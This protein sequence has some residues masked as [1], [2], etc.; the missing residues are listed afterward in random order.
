MQAIIIGVDLGG[1]NIKAGAIT[2]EGNVL[3]RCHRPTEGEGGPEKVCDNMAEAVRECRQNLP[4]GGQ[5]IGMGVGTPGPLDLAR[6]LVVDAPNLPGWENIPVRQMMEERTGLE[7]ELENDANAAALGEQWVGAGHGGSSLVLLTLGTGI[8]GGIVL[9]G[10]VW[11][12]FGDCAG[13]IGHMSID[14]EGPR[15][16]CGNWGCVEAHASATAMVRRMRETIE[17]GTGSSLADKLDEMTA[18]DIY[19]AAVDGDSAASENI[20]MTGFY[21]G[22]AV[23]NIMHIL[24]PEVV[25]FSGGVTAAGNMLLRPIRQTA[26]ERTM[27]ACRRDVKIRFGELGGD[28]GVIGAARSFITMRQ[29]QKTER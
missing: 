18:K 9:D 8:G 29:E 5:P 4:D 19:E 15:C 11:H 2:R 25:V 10:K 6:G 23:S 3:Y 16:N 1:T 13:E 20:H 24:N 14:P 27:E 22:V 12:G 17:D 28:A 26:R 21:L 7:C